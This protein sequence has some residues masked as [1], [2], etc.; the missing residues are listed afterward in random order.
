MSRSRDLFQLINARVERASTVLT[1]NKGCEDWGRVLGDEIMAAI[2]T[3]RQN[4]IGMR[5]VHIAR[6]PFRLVSEKH[7]TRL[8]L[9]SLL[10]A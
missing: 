7:N 1:S 5:D 6:R 3:D 2:L 10:R 4:Q 8:A 9:P